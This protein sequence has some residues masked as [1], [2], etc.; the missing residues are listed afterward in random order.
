MTDADKPAFLAALNELAALKP[1]AKLTLESYAAWWNALRE[2]WTLDDFRAACV[3]LRDTTEFMPNPFHFER[4]RRTATR[5]TAGEAWALVREAVRAGAPC[6]DDARI[7]ATVRVLGGMRTIGFTQSE[8]MQFLERRFVEHFE[9]I[10]DADDVRQAL[11][12][13]SGE[14]KLLDY[15]H[16][17]VGR[18]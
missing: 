16:G 1:G 17:P 8:Q 3:T 6:P 7:R 4:L 12:N 15:G 9:A 10:S 2:K 13:L 18:A 11:P 5:K 14:T